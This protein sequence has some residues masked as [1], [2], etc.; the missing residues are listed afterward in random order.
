MSCVLS[1]REDQEQVPS[2]HSLKSG[3]QVQHRLVSL[4]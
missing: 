4:R 3:T 1:G 2:E